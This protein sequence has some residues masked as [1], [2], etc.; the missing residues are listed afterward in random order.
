MK[1]I[2][3]IVPYFGKLPST[4]QLWLNSCKYNDTVNWLIFTDDR[5][6]YD[7]PRNVQVRYTTF[8]EMKTRIQAL[9]DFTVC[10]D[11][12]H[13]LCNFKPAQGEIFREELKGFDFWGYCDIDMIFGNIRKFLTEDIL[14]TYRKVLGHGHLTLFKNDEEMNVVY[15]KKVDG[16]ERYR[17]VFVMKNACTF[18]EDYYL[19]PNI[20]TICEACNIKVYDDKRIFNDIGITS[21]A[22][23][24]IQLMKDEPQKS[25]SVYVW[26]RGTLFRFWVDKTT[27]TLGREEV[28]YLHMQ[29]RELAVGDGCNTAE[30]FVVRPNRYER[31]DGDI[32]AD[33]VLRAGK[34]KLVYAHWWKRQFRKVWKTRGGFLLTAIRHFFKKKK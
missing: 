34:D 12:P 2:C 3:I 30:R 5:S 25:P 6:P 18:S 23:Y 32:D 15:R 21:H 31:Y 28:L 16:R 20:G 26:E 4:F 17:E 9:Y 29:K 13:A 14:S 33:F 1:S 10:L 27:R 11:N 8:D 24:P 22:F 19:K 7:Y